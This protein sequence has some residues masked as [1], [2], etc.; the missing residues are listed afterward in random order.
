[1]R[2]IELGA[3]ILAAILLSS[4]VGQAQPAPHPVAPAPSAEGERAPIPV[5]PEN[6]HP[7]TFAR[8]ILRIPGDEIGVGR[9]E[10][11]MRMLEELR[12][13]G[14]P[15]VGGE[16]LV[17]GVD[18]SEEARFL[19][20]GT[21][22]ELDCDRRAFPKEHRCRIG[23][24]WELKD[25]E[26]AKVTYVALTRF[27]GRRKSGEGQ[28]LAQD[29][30]LGSFRSLLSRREFVGALWRREPSPAVV[31]A[32]RRSFA[33]CAAP[34]HVMPRSAEA[35]LQAGVVVADEAGHG[36][37]T[38]ISPDG[39]VV[40]AAHVVQT[41]RQIKI[42][43]R[44][45]ETLAASVLRLDRAHDVALLRAHGL[46]AKVPCLAVRT[47]AMAIGEDVYAIGAP[48]DRALAFTVTRG[49]VS[50]YREV[51]DV[52]LLQTDASVNVGN[53][54]GA[55][56]DGSGRLVAVTTSKAFGSGVEGV[57]F[58]VPAAVGL[59]ALG[60]VPGE[61]SDPRI[62]EPVVPRAEPER[63]LPYVDYAD[64]IPGERSGSSKGS[65]RTPW[66]IAGGVSLGL[67]T[68]FLVSSYDA[69]A[70]DPSAV[71]R[72]GTQKTLGWG[73]IVVGGALIAVPFVFG[74]GA[75][76]SGQARG[77]AAGSTW[78][79]AVGPASAALR[80]TY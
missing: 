77:T 30:L 23:I 31:A 58:G 42:K 36:S 66:F 46:S 80:V 59:G 64:P 12:A 53:S 20:G 48:L 73:G 13:W 62:F 51:K 76:D 70:D 14:Y 5:R 49:I 22:T 3:T 45:G 63:P 21:V 33:R 18:S 26:L 55:L 24:I 8:L 75:D 50:G 40:T 11:R 25:R 4:S 67:G 69:D 37:G 9:E 16:S 27:A 79:L 71:E 41:S 35:V 74:I 54:G 19:L 47:D 15:A 44:S 52:T 7:L 39:L 1:M 61:A 72:A 65:A 78:S 10:Y 57:A 6:L 43:M 17:F 2:R 60:A 32:D 29:L 28:L 68:L 38:F 34:E 56:V